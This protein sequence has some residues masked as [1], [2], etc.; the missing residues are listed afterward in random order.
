[1]STQKVLLIDNYDSF[2]YNLAQYLWELGYDTTVLRNDKVSVSDVSNGAYTHIIISPGPGTPDESGVC[3]KII[4]EFHDKKPILGVCL[5]H[6][7]L[8][9]FFGAKIIRAKEPR[10][11]K[12]SQI[13]HNSESV[14]KGLPD[15]FTAT[16][17]HSL[18]I[19]EESLLKTDL[20]ITARSTDDSLVMGVQHKNLPVH[21][22][23]FHPESIMT[24]HGH[25]M[26]KNFL[27]QG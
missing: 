11:G 12:T 13:E 27:V 14:F 10:H 19:D 26:L 25:Q 22:V 8:G 7:C 2:T 18:I 15:K 24:E 4:E 16:R 9:Q 21:G 3:L 6:Q 23:Q 17:Y 5:G 1:M 20:R